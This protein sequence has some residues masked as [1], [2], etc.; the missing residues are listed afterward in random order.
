MI[1][2]FAVG[3]TQE[4][5]YQLNRYFDEQKE[6]RSLLRDV[7]VYIDSP[8][9]T[10][11]TA[12][13]RDNAQDFD[14]ETRARILSGDDPL[15]FV[16]LR[17]SKTQEDSKRLNLEQKPKVIISASGMCDAGRIRHHLKH[18]LWEANASIVFVGYQAEGTLGRR[19]IDGAKTVRLFGET[20]TVNA[21]ICSLEGFSGHGDREALLA[22]ASGFEKKPQVVFLVHGETKSKEDLADSLKLATGMDA[23]VVRGISEF[24][25]KKEGVVSRKEALGDFGGAE[26][27]ARMRDR[28]GV[29]REQLELILYNTQLA[30]TEKADPEWLMA[31]NNRLVNLE[32]DTMGLA[33]IIARDPNT[34]YSE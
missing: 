10:S 16:N 33:A 19:L 21:Q 34:D 32:K 8:M 15:S 3:R 14:E 20:V 31:V 2:A 4:L 1:P 29:V 18:H 13:F 25:L 9:A 28:V 30:A 7:M 27:S 23:I 11:A 5:I 24:E 22:W 26:G 17:F 6:M 12:V